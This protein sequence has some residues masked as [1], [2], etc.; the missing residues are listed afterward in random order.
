VGRYWVIGALYVDKDGGLSDF[1]V[2]WVSQYV[3]KMD[4]VSYHRSEW[5]VKDVE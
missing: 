4:E 1:V 2:Y 5:L 3:D